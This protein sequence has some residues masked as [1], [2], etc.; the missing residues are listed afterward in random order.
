MTYDT[1]QALF[2]AKARR[3]LL[4][5]FSG[6]TREASMSVLA[7]RA[8]LTPRAVAVEVGRLERAGLVEVEEVGGAHVVR[9][10]RSHPAARAL[11]LLLQAGASPA[12]ERVPPSAVRESLVAWGAPLPERPRPSL[13]L[14][15]AVVRG[16][17]L[18]RRDATVLR[19]LPV[20]VARHAETFDWAALEEGARRAKLRAEL[21]MLLDLTADLANLP[22]LRERALGLRDG[23]RTRTRF[24]P[25]VGS[26][27]EAELARRRT[28]KAAA[29]WHF[30]MNMTEEAFRS[31]LER[32]G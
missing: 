15:D 5:L 1:L 13:D 4:Q 20:V 18:A 3:A 16:L 17:A 28:P 9:A 2:P 21:G 26:A 24:F 12:P 30:A 29:R 25:E 14:A 31:T 7:R 32:H 10:N 19:V 6:K 23:R 11:S 8:G 22:S 27:Y